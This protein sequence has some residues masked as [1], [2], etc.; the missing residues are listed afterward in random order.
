MVLGTLEG[1]KALPD[2]HMSRL[3]QFILLV[4]RNEL[5]TSIVVSEMCLE[6]TN[7]LCIGLWYII[8]VEDRDLSG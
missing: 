3:P 1:S 8:Y 4:Q 6:D 2:I 7:Y 5:K